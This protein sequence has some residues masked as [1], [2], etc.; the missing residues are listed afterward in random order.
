M[1]GGDHAYGAVP[2]ISEMLLREANAWNAVLQLN[3]SIGAAAH[4][5][6]SHDDGLEYD[7][8][9]ETAAQREASYVGALS[10]LAAL[11]DSLTNETLKLRSLRKAR[12]QV[13]S[14]AL[15]EVMRQHSNGALALG[16]GLARRGALDLS[17]ATALVRARQQDARSQLAQ[18]RT[19]LQAVSQGGASLPPG[20]RIVIGVREAAGA[21]PDGPPPYGSSS[22]SLKEPGSAGSSLERLTM[23]M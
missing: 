2:P 1:Q 13:A 5:V 18:A 14:L 16:E 17:N 11:S 7:E 9:R 12:H 3:G 19:L 8:A 4:G 21:E 23:G 22:P 6:G 10:N 20:A 15:Q